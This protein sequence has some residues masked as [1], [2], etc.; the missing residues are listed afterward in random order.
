M[1]P[2]SGFGLRWSLVKNSE[3]DMSTRLLAVARELERGRNG[4]VFFFLVAHR[5]HMRLIKWECV[6]SKV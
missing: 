3:K 4:L 2:R 1:I 6:D 5:L